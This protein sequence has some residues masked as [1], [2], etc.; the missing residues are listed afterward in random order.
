M[1]QDFW[2]G[3]ASVVGIFF[4]HWLTSK[5]DPLCRGDKDHTFDNWRISGSD[6]AQVKTCKSCGFS[7]K[8]PLD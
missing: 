5:K 6:A 1:N 3:V 2:I 4:L 8:I 7:K